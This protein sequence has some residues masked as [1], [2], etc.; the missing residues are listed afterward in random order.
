MILPWRQQNFEHGRQRH[1][2]ERALGVESE[3]MRNLQAQHRGSTQQQSEEIRI[4][5]NGQQQI[6]E[7]LGVLAYDIAQ[8]S[9][10]R[11]SQ[12]QQSSLRQRHVAVSASGI[13]EQARNISGSSRHSRF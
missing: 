8:L 9:G 11:A 13:D 5:Q 7:R 10:D 2:E 1:D 3:L 6:N 12:Q 4:L